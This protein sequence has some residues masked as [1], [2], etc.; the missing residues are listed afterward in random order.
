MFL[1]TKWSNLSIKK[2]NFIWSVLI[3]IIS[4]SL[5]YGGIYLFMPRVYEAY[6]LNKIYSNIDMIKDTLAED[7]NIDLIDTLDK[8]SY[9]NNLELI[10]VE[11]DEEGKI[12]S[13]L[14]SSL[15]EGINNPAKIPFLRKEWGQ[16]I[17]GRDHLQSF[18]RHSKF[19][20][21]DVNEVVYKPINK[22]G[23][24]NIE[25]NIKIR[26]LNGKYSMIVHAAV[27]PLDEAATIVALFFPFAIV[28]IVVIAIT[29]STFYSIQISKP[30]IKINGV[31]KKMSELDFDNFIE[32]KGDDEI[33]QL[34]KS[35]NLMNEN[36][37]NSFEELEKVNSKLTE[38]IEFERKIEKQRRE[39]V[40]TISHELKSPITIISGQLE[41]MI[42]NIGK[43]KDREKYLNE[44]YDVVQK[45]RELV[46]ELLDMSRRENQKLKCIFTKVNLSILVNEILNDLYYFCE[47][48]NI[49]LEKYIEGN[50]YISGDINQL[51]KAITNIM[52]NSITH[53]PAEQKVV[54]KL[55]NEEFIVENTGVTIPDDE[56]N[57]IF[58]AFYRVD[59]SRNRK[60][61]GTGLGLY[62]V[63][64]ILDQHHNIEYSMY[65]KNK[66]VVFHMKFI[67]KN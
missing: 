12:T 35:L 67:D 11:K 18:D 17:N 13:I 15:R 62:I 55:S 46:Q 6:K 48:K 22:K 33:G 14:Y 21:I 65:N 3:I 34:S 25:E 10:V 20:V 28:A 56:I 57:N 7:K 8:F 5:L 51:T 41:G 61:G 54:V 58:N 37:K 53:S 23:N 30:L 27:S 16:S 40:A 32:I 36:L 29:I 38:E 63:K 31:A 45:M 64:S 60:T 47:D 4:F 9:D 43:Y 26:G 59:K 24:L 42:Y 49:K 50:V 39:F 44:S 52:K 2:K 1:K 66:S 19:K